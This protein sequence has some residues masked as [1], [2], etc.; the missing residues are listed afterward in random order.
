MAWCVGFYFLGFAVG[1]FVGIRYIPHQLKKGN[2]KAIR[3]A[4]ELLRRA[5][6][7]DPARGQGGKA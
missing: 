6:G 3:Q 1:M 4:R 2:P 7:D 5:Q